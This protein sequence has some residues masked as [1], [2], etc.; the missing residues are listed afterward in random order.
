MLTYPEKKP[1]FGGPFTL[2]RPL[3]L[4]QNPLGNSLSGCGHQNGPTP[5]IQPHNIIPQVPTGKEK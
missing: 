5:R 3:T 4:T 2:S 1:K